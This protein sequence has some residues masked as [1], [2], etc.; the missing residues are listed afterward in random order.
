VGGIE[1]LG[2]RTQSQL[3]TES[4]D[5]EHSVTLFAVL[6]REEGASFCDIPR[7]AKKLLTTV[8]K[9]SNPGYN[10]PTL[11]LRG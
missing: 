9:R 10:P 11:G 5:P 6:S 4:F 1:V 7:V 8:W 3:W 2:L